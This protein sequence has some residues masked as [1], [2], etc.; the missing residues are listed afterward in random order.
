MAL[1]LIELAEVIADATDAH[2]PT[3]LQMARLAREAQIVSFGGRGRHVPNA[4][5]KD[6][7]TLLIG[8]I[9]SP[10][11]ARAVEFMRSF[12]DLV[13]F[14][15]LT[16]FRDDV[17]EIVIN[18]FPKGITLRDA[19]AAGLDLLGS[20]DFARVYDLSQLVSSED[21]LT[22]DEQTGLAPVFDVSIEDAMFSAEILF[23]AAHVNFQHPQMNELESLRGSENSKFTALFKRIHADG[24]RFT[25]RIKSKRY[26]ENDVLLKISE[27]IHGTSFIEILRATW[28][29]REKCAA[30]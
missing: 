18:A 12:G 14:D 23:M 10:S 24:D 9:C 15:M 17:P 4:T 20:K 16:S 21:Q 5:T 2:R 3:V 8:L 19:I 25:S 28:P 27:A 1:N 22:D 6:A 7:A 26:V 30:M 11:P 29:E 13:R